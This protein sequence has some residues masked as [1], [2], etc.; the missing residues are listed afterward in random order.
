LMNPISGHYRVANVAAESSV[1]T[2][3]IMIRFRAELSH[4]LISDFARPEQSGTDSDKSVRVQTRNGDK[5]R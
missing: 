1:Q 4:L 5:S 3:H 2:P